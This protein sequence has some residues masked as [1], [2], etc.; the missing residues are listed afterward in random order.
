MAAARV[1]TRLE[2]P[3]EMRPFSEVEL[4]EVVERVKRNRRCSPT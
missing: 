2:P 3:A 4:D 1:P